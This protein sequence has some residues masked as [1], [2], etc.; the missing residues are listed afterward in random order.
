MAHANER[1]FSLIETLMAVSV[2]GVVS[3]ISIAGF[4]YAASAMSSDSGVSQVIA[5]IEQARDTA[6]AQR[7]TV[8]VQFLG[9]NEIRTTRSDLPSG[10]TLLGQSFLEGNVHFVQFSAVPDTPDG[11][12]NGAAVDLGGANS[13]NVLA[14]GTVVD[15]GGAPVS[16]TIFLGV[17]GQP[18]TA[19]AVTVFSGTGRVRGYR[20]NGT[21]W[22]R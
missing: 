9:V 10:T 4:G 12:G 16:G 21:Q 5:Q 3:A 2:M 19:R 1:G 17:N 7:R 15:I 6:I 8:H 20:W 22:L 14:D 11:F 13:F 18:A